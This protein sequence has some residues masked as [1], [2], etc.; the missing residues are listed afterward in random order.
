MPES[1]LQ[2]SPHLATILDFGSVGTQPVTRHLLLSYT[3]DYAIQYLQRNLR[4][5]W[6][7]NNKTVEEM[8]DSA[9]GN[10][11]PSNH[12]VKRWMRS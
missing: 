3:E 6:Q 10:M 8:L 7:R 9:E 1:A 5:Y 11:Q 12:A 4:P 2:E